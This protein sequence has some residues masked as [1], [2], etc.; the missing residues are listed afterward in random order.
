MALKASTWTVMVCVLLYPGNDV[1]PL[2]EALTNDGSG[3]AGIWWAGHQSLGA[4]HWGMRTQ[5]VTQELSTIS[6]GY[7]VGSSS[8]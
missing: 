8:R 6:R 5:Q 1:A 7:V 2:Q 4:Q 3:I